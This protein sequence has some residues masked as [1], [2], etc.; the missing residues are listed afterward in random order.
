MNIKNKLGRFLGGTRQWFDNLTVQ[1]LLKFILLLVILHLA[2]F[3]FRPLSIHL[4]HKTERGVRTSA[5]TRRP[6]PSR[7][8]KPT[9]R[10][11]RSTRP[12]KRVSPTRRPVRTTRPMP[13]KISPSKA[14]DTSEK[15]STPSQ[16][17][18]K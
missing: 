3:F 9:K 18:E 13:A 7:T 1:G 8:L 2:V 15:V 4:I 11:S 6:Q 12:T 10:S 5:V 17:A 14:V 16:G